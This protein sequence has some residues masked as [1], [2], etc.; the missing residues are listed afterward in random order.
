M[1]R[2]ALRFL[3]WNMRW[4]TRYVGFIA[5]PIVRL[6]A[7]QEVIACGLGEADGAVS[8]IYT[9]WPGRRAYRAVVQRNTA[10]QSA[11]LV[12]AHNFSGDIV[13]QASVPSAQVGERYKI[14]AESRRGRLLY[15]PSI[16]V[17]ERTVYDDALLSVLVHKESGLAVF[18]WKDARK[19][20]PLIYFLAL[21]DDT[22]ATLA[23]LYTRAAQWADPHTKLASLSVGPAHAPKLHQ[24]KDY[25]VKLLLVDFDGWVSHFA[26]Q[27]FSL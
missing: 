2:T 8:I 7:N 22:G 11:P 25:T 4:M 18:Q 5:R 14:L 1:K 6:Y 21:E 23:A 26:K 15:S 12:P 20:D 13:L 19:Y 9:P 27:H 24:G 16:T 10:W 17:K 3:V